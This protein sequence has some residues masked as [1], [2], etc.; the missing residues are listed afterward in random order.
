MSQHIRKLG[1]KLWVA[2]A[3]MVWI[4]AF[5][6]MRANV[7]DLSAGEY[8]AVEQN[9]AQAPAAAAAASG[10]TYVGQDTCLTCHDEAMA[11]YKDSPHHRAADPRTPAATQGCESCH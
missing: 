4:A 3:F 9:P 10:A 6:S 8:S 11:A 7:P 2:C 5:G 1:P